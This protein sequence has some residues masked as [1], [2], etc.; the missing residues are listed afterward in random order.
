MNANAADAKLTAARS[1][2]TLGAK[3]EPKDDLKSLPMPELETKLASSL[4]GLSQAE[5]KNG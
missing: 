5:R 3:P 1:Q 2:A 4:D